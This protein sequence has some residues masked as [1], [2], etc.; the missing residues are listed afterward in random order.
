[1]KM[2]VIAKDL[3]AWDPDLISPHKQKELLVAI[4]EIYDREHAVVIRLD[5]KDIAVAVMVGTH[6]DDLPRA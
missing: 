5:D 2:A 3:I 6:E 4:D 1:M